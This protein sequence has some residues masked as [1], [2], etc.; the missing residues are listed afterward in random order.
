MLKKLQ[1]EN[2]DK[3]YA[4]MEEAF[5]P[6]ER[7]TYDEQK[8]LLL[9]RAYSVYT[10][11]DTENDEIKSFITVYKFEKFS[12]LEHFATNPKYRN[13]GLGALVLRELSELLQCKICFEVEL[14][15]TEF[16]KRRIEF[17]KRNG[18]YLNGYEYTQ[19]AISKGK[20]PIPLLIMTSGG[21]VT[22]GEFEEIKET[23]YK[24]VY[25]I[26]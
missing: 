11:T 22:K 5:P 12:F 13:Q 25:G 14:P 20:K 7:R 24:N 3:V 21:S 17:Y 16:A 19:P 18:F 8:A 2:F 26:K 6:D 4:I 10:L 9:N 1:P 23:L 15:D